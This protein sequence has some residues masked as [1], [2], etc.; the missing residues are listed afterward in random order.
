[1]CVCVLKEYGCRRKDE[2]DTHTYDGDEETD[3]GFGELVPDEGVFP[4]EHL[5]ETIER[6]E[7]RDD[8]GFVGLLTGCEAGLVHAVCRSSI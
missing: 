6:V 2:R 3:V 7:D 1:M 5:L 8:G 4:V